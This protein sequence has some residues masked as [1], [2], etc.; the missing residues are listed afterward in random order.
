MNVCTTLHG[1][2]VDHYHEMLLYMKHQRITKVRRMHPL[3]TMNIWTKLHNNPSSGILQYFSLVQSS[4]LK[5][6]FCCLVM[7]LTQYQSFFPL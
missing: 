1:S 3:G 6:R 5:I 4:K 7:S 2:L